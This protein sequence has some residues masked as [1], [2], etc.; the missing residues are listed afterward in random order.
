MIMMGLRKLIIDLNLCDEF[1]K[2]DL[3]LDMIFNTLP[4][5]ISQGHKKIFPK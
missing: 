5:A 3:L 4:T 2:P 1:R